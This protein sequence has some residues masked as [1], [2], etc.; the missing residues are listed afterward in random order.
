MS[1][2]QPVRSM[3]GR[4]TRK[5]KWALPEYPP[6]FCEAE[7]RSRSMKEV[8]AIG[9]IRVAMLANR[10]PKR[11]AALRWRDEDREAA[12]QRMKE[13]WKGGAF[14]HR[15]LDWTELDA[16]IIQADRDGCVWQTFAKK[17]GVSVSALTRRRK[18]LGLKS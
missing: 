17:L 6:L 15:K 8:W 12:S 14:D 7:R 2:L 18:T 4:G 16:L 11:E 9:D 5:A 13:S 10:D 3:H 1:R